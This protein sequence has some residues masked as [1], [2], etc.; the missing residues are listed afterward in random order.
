MSI[1]GGTEDPLETDV[2]DTEHVSTSM[3]DLSPYYPRER[4][5]HTDLEIKRNSG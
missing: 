2:P 3:L 4:L 5:S 1:V